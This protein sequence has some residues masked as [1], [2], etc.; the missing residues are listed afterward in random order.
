MFSRGLQ[1]NGFCYPTRTMAKSLLPNPTCTRGLIIRPD[2]NP[3]IWVELG[4]PTGWV[5]PRVQ[6]YPQTTNVQSQHTAY[7]LLV[8]SHLFLYIFVHMYILR[9]SFLGLSALNLLNRGTI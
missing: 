4:K 9:I 1:V 7:P 8:S 6:V 3:R 2:L 5:N